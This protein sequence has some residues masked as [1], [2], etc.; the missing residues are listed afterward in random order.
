MRYETV[1]DIPQTTREL[2]PPDEE[3]QKIYLEAYNKAWDNYDEETSPGEQSRETTA[4]RDGWAALNRA[5]EQDAEGNWYPQGEKP[6]QEE[7]EESKGVL[8]KL[9]D[10]IT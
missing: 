9:K 4:H 1:N 10:K 3:A 6:G 2:L 7:S 5:Y 8:D